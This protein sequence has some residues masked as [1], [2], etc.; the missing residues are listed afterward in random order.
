MADN[1]TWTHEGLTFTEVASQPYENCEFSAGH[2]EGHPVD[3]IYIKWQRD[4][5]GLLGLRPDEA[6]ALGYLLNAALWSALI[7]NVDKE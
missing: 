6:A 3:T 5:G 7:E 4:G 1:K 2:I